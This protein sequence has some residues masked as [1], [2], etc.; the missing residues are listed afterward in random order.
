MILFKAT[1][2]GADYTSIDDPLNGWSIFNKGTIICKTIDANHDTIIN[3]SNSKIIIEFLKH[4]I[5]YSNNKDRAL[6]YEDN[7]G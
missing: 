6:I 4:R 7:Y 5:F 3:A 1:Q 2:L